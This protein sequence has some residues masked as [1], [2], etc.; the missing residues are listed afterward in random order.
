MNEY[1]EPWIWNGDIL[2][3][4]GGEIH[5][6]T[7]SYDDF[8]MEITEECLERAVVCVN[9]LAGCPTETL[10]RMP[11]GAVGK[12]LGDLF[13]APVV[14]DGPFPQA[15]MIEAFLNLERPKP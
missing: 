10:E 1:N 15:P 2:T 12:L 6:Q 14:V 5:Y 8:G 9:A 7:S 3:D 11:V 4:S 13:S